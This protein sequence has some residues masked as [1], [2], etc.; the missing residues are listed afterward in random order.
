MVSRSHSRSAF[1][2]T[3]ICCGFVV[4]GCAL[5]TPAVDKV[6]Q[7]VD[8]Y[9]AKMTYTERNLLRNSINPT[10]AGNNI[11]VHCLGDPPESN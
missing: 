5:L 8:T 2:V 6:K 9:C 7:G 11:H 4:A 10:P 3:L 1:L